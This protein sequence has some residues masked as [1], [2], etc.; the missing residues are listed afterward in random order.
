[1][2]NKI[3]SEGSFI[4][5]FG[6]EVCIVTDGQPEVQVASKSERGRWYDVTDNVCQ[7]RGFEIRQHCR[8]Q[9]LA[10]QA[11]VER[12]KLDQAPCP[13]CGVTTTVRQVRVWGCC[14]LCTMK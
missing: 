11:R 5:T 12:V 13:S 2:P 14:A 4:F 8:H 7:C 3:A 1:M 6:D 10:A 9:E